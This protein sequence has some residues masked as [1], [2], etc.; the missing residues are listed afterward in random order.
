MSF[1][2]FNPFLGLFSIVFLIYIV[3]KLV[4]FAFNVNDGSFFYSLEILYLFFFVLSIIIVKVV[5]IVKEK[6]FD[7][8]GMSFLLAT[9][10]KMIICYLILRPL[11]QLPKT[12]SATERINFFILFTVFLAIE[13]VFTIRLVNENQKS[14]L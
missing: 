14:T 1:K 10:I 7:N 12:N 4:F 5:L 13:T 6:S 11:L 3:H 2:T 9:S 8:V